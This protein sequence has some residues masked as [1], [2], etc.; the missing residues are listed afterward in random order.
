MKIKKCDL[1]LDFPEYGIEKAEE[2]CYKFICLL[3]GSSI[4]RAGGC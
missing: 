2:F 3:L 4:G 1:S